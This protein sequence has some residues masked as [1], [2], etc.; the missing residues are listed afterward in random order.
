MPGVTQMIM[1]RPVDS[2]RPA[3]ERVLMRRGL[4][5]HGTPAS[6]AMIG[7]RGTL[8]W[9]AALIALS[10]AAAGCGLSSGKSGAHHPVSGGTV[11][12]ALPANT[13]PNYI[14]PFSP[15]QYFTQV[16]SDQLQYLL[17]RPLY[18]FGGN[19]QPYLNPALSLAK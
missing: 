10:L 13:N 1:R 7:R 2:G 12:Y 8:G 11:T 17:Y 9:A 4:R 19:G 15:G 14:F 18:W 3:R 6:R 16:N 5:R